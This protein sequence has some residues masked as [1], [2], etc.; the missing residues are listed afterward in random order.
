MLLAR[1]AAEMPSEKRQNGGGPEP[2]AKRAA[3]EA[4]PAVGSP[5][6]D[7]AEDDVDEFMEEEEEEEEAAA[8]VTECTNFEIKEA[9]RRPPLEPIEASHDTISFQQLSIDYVIMK[10]DPAYSRSNGKRKLGTAPVIRMFGV[11]EKGNSVLAFVHGFEPYFYILCPQH[12]DS[13]E[14]IERFRSLLNSKME[15]WALR[16]RGSALL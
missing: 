6:D 14:E 10:E 1:L 16:V 13:A 15:R 9:W 7:F 5:P 11:T 8:L 3:A 12:I 2:A 4:H